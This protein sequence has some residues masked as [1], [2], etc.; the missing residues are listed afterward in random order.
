MW[1]K[2]TE[3]LPLPFQKVLVTAEDHGMRFVLL[4]WFSGNEEWQYLNT[5][6]EMLPNLE[7]LKNGRNNLLMQD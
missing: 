7:V 3:A 1:I 5:C 6:V 4:A 2:I